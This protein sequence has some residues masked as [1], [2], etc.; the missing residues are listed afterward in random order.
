MTT[1][2]MLHILSGLLFLALLG[3]AVYALV[4]ARR[5]G[6][7]NA[8]F[9]SIMESV[10]A[11]IAVL[12]S[13][14]AIKRSSASTAELLGLK[15]GE[16]KGRSL[17]DFLAPDDKLRC[18]AQNQF[19][20]TFTIIPLGSEARTI[21]VETSKLP[22]KTDEY[23]A[24]ITDI[25]QETKAR[26]ELMTLSI[27]DGLTGL[28]NRRHF[29][30]ALE[31]EYHR[32]LRSK[33]MLALIMVDIDY[34]KRFN[35]D[36]GHVQGD[37]CLRSV[38][39]TL[40]AAI[41]RPG[42]LVARYGGEEFV[43]IL[44]ET[45][46]EGATL[47]AERMRAAVQALSIPHRDTA[48]ED[49]DSVVTASFG[50]IAGYCTQDLKDTDLVAKADAMLYKAKQNGRNRVAVSPPPDFAGGGIEMAPLVWSNKY[51][52]S[53][54]KIDRE[55]KGLFTIANRIYS[56]YKNNTPMAECSSILDGFVAD[57]A[58]HFASEEKVMESIHY[59]DR[60]IHAE[61][62]RK[63]HQISEQLVFQYKAGKM[64]LQHLFMFIAYEVVQQHILYSDRKIFGK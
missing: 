59:A 41:F 54:E 48:V 20:G 51:S 61:E 45:N 13:N 27:T 19:A 4:R 50:V 23:V 33:D 57:L 40:E 43:A 30:E 5:S 35:D 53:N 56:A 26:Q 22:P 7:E 6:K 8:L 47:V 25:T 11:G 36:Y 42:D 37:N 64:S 3:G 60:K 63:L 31:R 58:A 18:N 55:H 14:G 38:A 34:F 17:A 39:K 2:D 1:V 46:T 16:L 28:A 15:G 44:P 10:P 24:T 9:H 62:H 32:H 21:H 52:C 12:T 29:D 49:A